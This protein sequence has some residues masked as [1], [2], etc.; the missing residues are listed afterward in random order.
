MEK[1]RDH[2]GRNCP[3][4]LRLRRGIGDSRIS[5]AFHSHSDRSHYYADRPIEQRNVAA[6]RSRFRDLHQFHCSRQ[7]SER[8]TK[9]ELHRNA[10]QLHHKTLPPQLDPVPCVQELQLH[11]RRKLSQ[12]THHVVV[13]AVSELCSPG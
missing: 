10:I 9:H 3:S 1:A 5:D 7:S 6:C 2:N 12:H 8:N 4:H 13:P 11:I